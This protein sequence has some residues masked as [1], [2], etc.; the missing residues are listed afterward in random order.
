MTECTPCPASGMYVPLVILI[1][2]FVC[3]QELPQWSQWSEW[4]KVGSDKLCGDGK[5]FVV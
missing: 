4:T 2:I 3:C 1:I 5:F